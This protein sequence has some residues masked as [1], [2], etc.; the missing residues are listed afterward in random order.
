LTPRLL[1]DIGKLRLTVGFVGEKPQLA[2]WQSSFLS[3]AA[4]AFARPVF[5][6]TQ[7]LARYHGVVEA[8]RRVHD[9]HIGIG[10]VYHLF[11]LPEALEEELHQL[12]LENGQMEEF[13]ASLTSR[14]AAEQVFQ[15]LAKGTV[16]L[17]AAGPV[18]VGF[19]KGLA[20][21]K[22]WQRVAGHYHTATLEETPS[23]PYFAD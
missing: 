19:A 6:R 17:S 20:D 10:A 12:M 9:S 5:G 23:F 7:L 8:A 22:A 14:A 15:A 21:A 16:C 3:P 2:W 13:A 1:R 4:I 18:H 11:R